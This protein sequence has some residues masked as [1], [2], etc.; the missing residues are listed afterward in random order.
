M[1]LTTRTLTSLANGVSRQPAILRSQDQTDA[2][3]N[4]WGQIATGVGRR[5]PTRLIRQLGDLNLGTA[6]LHHIN[7]DVGERYLVVIDQGKV[8]VFDQQTGD[9]KTVTAPDGWG[10]LDAPGTAYRAVTVADYT[11]IVNTQKTPQMV[12]SVPTPENPTPPPYT[13]PAGTV[14]PGGTGTGSGGRYNPRE[15]IP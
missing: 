13:P 1:S 6:A 12:V 10:Y 5:P 11:F 3:I 8:R 7:R 14:D 9:E 15:A 4:T 2:E